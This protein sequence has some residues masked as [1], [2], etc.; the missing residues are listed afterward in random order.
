MFGTIYHE[1]EFAPFDRLR[2]NGVQRLMITT[3]RQSH[4]NDALEQYC[5]DN[6]VQ[7]QCR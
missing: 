4:L 2:T 3:P 7:C 5:F 1:P 6:H